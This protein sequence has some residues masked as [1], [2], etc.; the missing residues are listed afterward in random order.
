MLLQLSRLHW[1]GTKDPIR[2]NPLKVEYF[3]RRMI[4][5]FLIPS[6]APYKA[7]LHEMFQILRW[8]TIIRLYI[9][10]MVVCK[11]LIT[12]S[13]LKFHPYLMSNYS[14][15]KFLE[16]G[17]HVL[18][19]AHGRMTNSKRNMWGIVIFGN[20]LL[21]TSQRQSENTWM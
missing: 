18:L 2:N 11:A 8:K 12:G 14:F 19:H 13:L 1:Y 15:M 3:Q 5:F 10:A 21:S 4:F 16:F 9:H 20:F 6:R 7:Y 17:L